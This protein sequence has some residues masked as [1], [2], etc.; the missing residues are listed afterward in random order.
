MRGVYLAPTLPA[1]I[2][3][4]RSSSLSWAPEALDLPIFLHP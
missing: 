2:S 3:T 1:A 4:I